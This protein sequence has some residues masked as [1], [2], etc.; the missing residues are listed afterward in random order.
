M[1]DRLT[2]KTALITGAG[3]GIGQQ[4]AT[5]FLAEGA[6]VVFSDRNL[7]AAAAAAADHPTPQHRSPRHQR[8]RQGHAGRTREINS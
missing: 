6:R 3:S 8:E 2:G 1:S 7:A 5:R 4:V